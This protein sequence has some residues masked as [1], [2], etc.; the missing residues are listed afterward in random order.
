MYE[1]LAVIMLFLLCFS[2]IAG[3]LEKTV[4]SGPMVYL[5]FGFLA[6]PL[7]LGLVGVP[8]GPALLLGCVAAATAPAATLDTLMVYGTEG[9]FSRL[10]AA[11]V[12]IDDAWALILFSLGLAAQNH[13]DLNLRDFV[14]SAGQAQAADRVFQ[15]AHVAGPRI[16]AHQFYGIGAQPPTSSGFAFFAGQEVI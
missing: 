11:I 8:P 12:A 3:R 9:R 10:L 4:I 14:G 2:L 13:F 7:V 5:G 15:L 1:N 6:G 16:A